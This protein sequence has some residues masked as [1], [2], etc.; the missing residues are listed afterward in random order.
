[1]QSDGGLT[2]MNSWVQ[3]PDRIVV[4]K[5]LFRVITFSYVSDSMGPG[6]FF[7]GQRAESSV[8]RSPLT[9]KRPICPWLDSIWAALLPTS[10]V[11]V[12]ATSMC[13]RAQP[14]ASRSKLRRYSPPLSTRVNFQHDIWKRYNNNFNFVKIW[15]LARY[16]WSDNNLS[17]NIIREEDW[18]K[19]FDKN[20][21]E[22]GREHSC[23]RGWIDAFL[24]V[25]SVRGR[26]RERRGASWPS[27]LQEERPS[28]C[29]RCESRSRQTFARIFP[30]DIWPEWERTV[31]QVSND[32]SFSNS[33]Q[34]STEF[35]SFYFLIKISSE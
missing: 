34:S 30:E 35:I 7:P 1:M 8:M 19:R 29:Y 22:V 13:T 32:A 3:I 20:W 14:Q 10:V 15:Y 5:Q 4:E 25:G 6:P 2:P 33:H 11:S 24:Q 18:L 9:A 26:A 12:A 21:V 16:I 31:G 28:G 27:L 23:G 17:K